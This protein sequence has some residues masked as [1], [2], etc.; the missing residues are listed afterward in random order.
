MKD[1]E[2]KKFEEALSARQEMEELIFRLNELLFLWNN[3]LSLI[4]KI[5][6][7][8]YDSKTLDQIDDKEELF[9]Y[10]YYYGSAKAIDKNI[11]MLK[12]AVK[13]YENKLLKGKYGA[14]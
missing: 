7:A 10:G 14:K 1:N 3:D 11:I 4:K 9:N 2:L 5:N 13:E 8:S 12:K 6:L